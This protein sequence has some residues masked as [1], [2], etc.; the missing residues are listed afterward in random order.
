VA[1]ETAGFA[2]AATVG[3]LTAASDWPGAA[4]FALL[5]GAGSVEGVLLGAGQAIAMS[6]LQLPRGIVRRWPVVTSAAAVLAW[7]I[8]LLL[9]SG[10]IPVDR[11]SPAAW[12]LAAILGAVLLL[13]IPVAQ[14]LLLRSAIP[15]ASRWIGVNVLAWLLGITWTFAPSPVVNASTPTITLIL[16]YAVAGLLMAITV[17]IVTGLCWRGWLKRGVVRTV[18]S[19]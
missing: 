14:Y 1:G 17:A 5:L 13:S 9:F 8:G 15:G 7:A 19:T 6:R 12:L 4:D 2:V 18:E 10:S 11:A 3:A 16:T